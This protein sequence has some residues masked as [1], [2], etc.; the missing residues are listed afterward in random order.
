MRAVGDRHDRSHRP[1]RRP[2]HDDRGLRRVPPGRDRWGSADLRLARGPRRPAARR[3]RARLLP[4]CSRDRAARGG[5]RG[6]GDQDRAAD[7][8][9]AAGALAAGHADGD[10]R[11]PLR[12]SARDR[13]HDLRPHIRCL[14]PRRR[15]PRRRGSG[16]RPAARRLLRAG[17]CSPDPRPGAAR[18]APGRHP[19]HR[20]DVRAAR[21]LSR[22]ASRRRRRAHR[23]GPGADHR[24]GERRSGWDQRRARDGSVRHGGRR[25]SSSGSG[26]RR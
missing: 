4:G 1:H 25:S 10:G 17:P 18:R 7:P 3:G 5:A 22:P 2:P 15:Q 20:A 21:R 13:L 23:G 12:R 9:A 8:A 19:R 16:A 14:G 11:R 26:D 6:A 24:P